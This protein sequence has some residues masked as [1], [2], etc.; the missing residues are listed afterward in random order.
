MNKRVLVIDDDPFALY[1]NQEVI[2]PLVTPTLNT[3]TRAGDALEVLQ[4]N[5]AKDMHSLIFLDLNMPE[6]NG[7]EFLDKISEF[8]IRPDV[9]VVI[10]TS[11]IDQR[12]YKRALQH[13]NVVD[14]IVKP[15]HP[16]LI[17]DL[18]QNQ[19]ISTFFK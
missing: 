17:Q 15:I 13:P 4:E 6:M 12:D 5:H 19:Q 3:Y 10:I 14:F 18:A 8:P 7:W 9:F 2:E 16:K 11:S 1:I